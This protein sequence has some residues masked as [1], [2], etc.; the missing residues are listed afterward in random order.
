MIKNKFKILPLF[1]AAV[2]ILLGGCTKKFLNQ[3]TTGLLTEEQAQSKKG[4]QQ[5]LIGAYAALKGSGWEGGGSNWVYGSIEGGEA[6][7]GSDAGDQANIVPIQQYAALPTN[8]FF[9]IKW[10]ALYEGVARSNSTIRIVTK[11]TDADITE[12]DKKQILAEARFLRGFYHFEAKKMWNKIPFVDETINYGDGNYKVPNSEDE[13]P[14]IMEDLEFAKSNLLVNPG[15]PGRI[16]KWGATAMLAKALLFQ[17]KY[18]EARPIFTDVINNGSTSNG[19]K[20]SLAP[21]FD[22]LFNADK[23]NEAAVRAES[24][25]A[26]EASINDGSGGNNANYDQV[27]NFPY[28]GGPGGCCGFFQPSFEFVNS[29]RTNA[30]G[31]PLLDGSYN[32]GANQVKTDQGL[33][34]TDPFTPDAG[35]LDPRL[36]W[37]VGRRGIP[38]LDWGNHPGKAWIRDQGNG[39]P[40]APKKNAYYKS[41]A[42]KLTDGTSWASGLTAINY[43]IMRFADVLLMAAECEIDGGGTLE[44]AREYVNLV[45]ARAAKAGTSVP[46][47][48]ATYVIST[49]ILPWTVAA[50]ARNAV[51]FE[52]KLE[53]G[54]EGHRFFDLVRWGIAD[55]A[56]NSFLAYEKPK[57]S[58]GYGSATFTKGKNEYF[59]IPQSQIDLH[60]TGGSSTLNQNPGY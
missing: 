14:K 51:R 21:A 50:D 55:V 58:A 41:Q 30:A 15:A 59:P 2:F 45:R 38:Y 26:Y 44:K 56:I 54:M 32:V 33:E 48:S 47:A 16:N 29:F 9:N 46:G 36:D 24:L 25:F 34:A 43:K 4:A 5:F 42:G 11:L 57:L 18:A 17:G 53:L 19:I 22:N 23:E 7:K 6:N 37:T 31:L 35:N 27:L 40:F 20:Y 60:T 28:N 13:W 3:D 39:G 52:R 8:S 10:S 12:D 49:Y 1:I